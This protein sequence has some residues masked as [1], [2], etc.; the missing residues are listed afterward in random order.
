MKTTSTM[1]SG[2]LLLC[3]LSDSLLAQPRDQ[4]AHAKA[5]LQIL[6]LSSLEHTQPAATA[7]NI[8]SVRASVRKQLIKNIT[9]RD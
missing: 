8:S 1:L 9:L 2:A 4:H 7:G 3:L 6:Q 5:V